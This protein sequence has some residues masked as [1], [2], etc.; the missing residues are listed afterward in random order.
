MGSVAT[1][2]VGKDLYAVFINRA[3]TWSGV[4]DGCACN[5]RSAAAEAAGVAMLVPLSM[6]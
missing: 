1:L 5:R 2:E 3:F 6:K 4:S